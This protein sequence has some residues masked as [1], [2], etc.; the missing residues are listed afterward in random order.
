MHIHLVDLVLFLHIAVAVFAFGVAGLLLTALAQ[1]RGADSVAV[2]RSW[3]HLAHRVEPWFPILVIVLIA[4]GGWLIALSH[5]QFSWGD[6]WVITAVVTL[7]VMEAY[8]GAVL[9]P[10]G[11]KLH[12]IIADAPAGP[13]PDQVHAA[14]MNPLVWAGAWGE[15][16]LAAGVLFLMPTKPSGAWPVVIVAAVGLVAVAI[17]VRLSR[18]ATREPQP[19]A[20]P[21]A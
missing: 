14:V 4:L 5:S 11:K 3:Q 2:L 13:V 6:G 17:G 9:A 1:M 16:G 15:M 20:T 12:A 21:A 8:G 18:T 10:H 7:A 19:A